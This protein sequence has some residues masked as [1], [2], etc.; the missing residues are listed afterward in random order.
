MKE[1][2]KVQAQ[3]AEEIKQVKEEM[4]QV[5]EQLHVMADTIASSAQTSPQPSYADIACSPPTSQPSNIHMLSSMRTILSL[6]MDT[7]FC[8]IDIL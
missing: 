8:T 6:F 7:L 3:I 4:Q 1:L 5:K 2:I